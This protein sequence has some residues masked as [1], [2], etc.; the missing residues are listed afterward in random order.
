MKFTQNVEERFNSEEVQE[1]AE[2]HSNPDVQQLSSRTL[3]IRDD[4]LFPPDAQTRPQDVSLITDISNCP[5]IRDLVSSRFRITQLIG[6]ST[7]E[8]FAA[9]QY[10][11]GRRQDRFNYWYH[12]T[13]FES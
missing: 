3:V 7:G 2:E 10:H 12:F 8:D 5:L 9:K 13:H 6:T 11:A 4:E 1:N